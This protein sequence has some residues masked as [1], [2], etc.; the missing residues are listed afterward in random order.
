MNTGDKLHRITLRLNDEQ[1]EFI[2]NQAQIMDLS[3]SQLLRT[4]ISSTMALQKSGIFDEEG[5]GREND[6][7]D[8]DNKL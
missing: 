4:L 2:K 5:S 3:P 6:K 1:F 7:A 8:I